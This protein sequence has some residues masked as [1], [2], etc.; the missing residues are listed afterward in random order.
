M[1]TENSSRSID[2]FIK[3]VI[4][5]ILIIAS[6][7]IAK[8]FLLLIVWA[9]LVAVA[10]Y[11]FYEKIINLFKGKKKGLVTTLFVLVLLA[12]IIVP[13]SNM[14]SSAAD[15]TSELFSQFNEGELKISPPNES[16]KTWPLIGEQTYKMWSNA[17]RDI[18]GFIKS[19]PEEVKA[20][21]GWFFSAITGLMGSIVLSLVAL[22][23]AGIFMSSAKE[24]Y[25]TGV[26]FANKLMDGK[27]EKLMEMCISTIRSVVK[28]ILLVGVIQAILAFIGFQMIGLSTAGILAFAVLLAAIIQ[29]PV[30]LVAIP[31]I[32]YVFSF[33]ETTP[34]IIFAVYIFV[35]SILDNF[36]KPMLLAKGLETPMI[37]ILIGAIGGMMF[38]GILGLFIGPVILAIAHRLYMNWVSS[39][40][41]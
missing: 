37:V 35:V 41:A 31:V 11:P 2:A 14:A 18:Q 8:P 40:T 30:T 22:I 24:G 9:I 28:G 17:S 1:K 3:I 32:I 38:L 23:I 15:S 7:L 39:S 10:L 20:S 27:G 16:V 26:V 25:K 13:A 5:S 4:L 33:A 12:V 21:V 6:Y 34:A 29:I 19:Y 36:L